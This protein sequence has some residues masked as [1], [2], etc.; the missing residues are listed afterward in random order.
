[1]IAD[2]LRKD[3]VG[4]L[5]ASWAKLIGDVRQALAQNDPRAVALAQENGWTDESLAELEKLFTEAQE[6]LDE[7]EKGAF[8]ARHEELSF[9]QTVMDHSYAKAGMVDESAGQGLASGVPAVTDR[10]LKAEAKPT[11]GQALFSSIFDDP[12]PLYIT[13][14]IKAVASRKIRGSHAWSDA[15]PTFTMAKRSR[16][17]IVGDWGT[18]IKRADVIAGLMRQAMEETPDRE[19]HAVHLGDIYFCGWPKESQERFLDHWPVKAGETFAHSWCLNGNHDM[20]CGGYGLYDVVL[21]DPRFKEQGGCTYFA[22][23]ND[24]WQIL[25]LD[26]SYTEWAYQG[27]QIPWAAAKRAQAPAKK[28]LLLTHHQP[29][30]DYEK[31]DGMAKLAAQSAPLLKPGVL[32]GWIWGHEHRCTVYKPK[33]FTFPDGTAGRLPLGS[34]LGHGGVPAHPTKTAGANTLYVLTASIRSGF[35]KFGLFG[36]GILDIDGADATLTLVDEQG[37]RTQ[38][39]KLDAV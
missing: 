23:E 2:L 17:V 35:E 38:P 3:D 28:G 25:G 19:L 22:L 5:T 4:S 27:N 31:D 29:F 9:A 8:I 39:F 34:C 37:N 18:G 24:S 12:N 16:L 26:T 13:E 7:E 14:G 33:D 10:S 20:Y 36:F 15:A 6:G 32:T 30:S 1:M 11:L 21:K